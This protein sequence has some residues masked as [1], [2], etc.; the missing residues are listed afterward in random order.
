[1]MAQCV[2]SGLNAQQFEKGPL[3]FPNPVTDLLT[4]R[5]NG[6]LRSFTICDATGSVIC[7]ENESP[8]KSISTAG[9]APGIYFITLS[10]GSGETI[11]KFI[12]E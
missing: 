8:G 7:A 6:D 1:M 2:S 12:V 9:W 5:A 10:T 3:L 4:I 11:S